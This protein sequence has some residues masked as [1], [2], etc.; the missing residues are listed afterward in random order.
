M[1]LEEQ[2]ISMGMTPEEAKKHASNFVDGLKDLGLSDTKTE[3]NPTFWNWLWNAKTTEPVP[4]TPAPI[5]PVIATSTV[6]PKTEALV[7]PSKLQVSIAAAL[8][9][10]GV[11]PSLVQLYSGALAKTMTEFN[12]TT[13]QRQAMFLA[14]LLHESAMLTTLSENLNYSA[15]GLTITFKKYFTA[16]KAAQYARQPQR[17]ANLVYANRMG[18]GTEASGDGWRYRGRGFIQL[19]GKN[20]YVNCGKGLGVDLIKNP[21][22]LL[23]P[24]GAARSAGWFWQS[25]NLNVT[26]DNNDIRENTSLIN[27]LFNGLDHRTNLYQSLLKHVS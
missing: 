12:I 20:N 9:K 7:Q 4:P 23:T 14:Q 15:K 2:F 26:A 10:I 27:V 5:P 13:K 8:T 21:D 19:T 16:A 24:E 6:S 1:N 25:R 18:N 11:R 22:Y 3:I 17:I